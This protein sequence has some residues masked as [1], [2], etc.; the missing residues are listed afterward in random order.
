LG[1]VRDLIAISRED[2]E[3]RDKIYASIEADNL[4][5]L[6]TLYNRFKSSE[7]LMLATARRNRRDRVLDRVFGVVGV[8]SLLLSVVFWFWPRA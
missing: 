1:E 8:V 6:I 5:D 3:N 2:R 4:G 7:G